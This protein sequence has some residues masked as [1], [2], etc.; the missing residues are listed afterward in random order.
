[1][2]VNV[3]TQELNV[4]V[5]QEDNDTK[6][7]TFEKKG[8]TVEFTLGG[9]TKSVNLSDLVPATQADR[10]L[11]KVEYD[12]E[13][14]Q[15]VFT[16]SKEGDEDN[17]F[18][19]PVE[20]IFKLE[21]EEVFNNE[22]VDINLGF[23]NTDFWSNEPEKGKCIAMG[24]IKG[25]D[26]YVFK[27]KENEIEEL[28][29]KIEE[30]NSKRWL[31]AEDIDGFNSEAVAIV[32][33]NGVYTIVNNL[34]FINILNASELK[35]TAS[36]NYVRIYVNDRNL[37]EFS[38][39]S[40]LYDEVTNTNKLG[41]NIQNN[42]DN[43]NAEDEV[44]IKLVTQ[45]ANIHKDGKNTSSEITLTFTSKVKDLNRNR[46]EELKDKFYTSD[47]YHLRQKV[48]DVLK[49]ADN[50]LPQTILVSEQDVIKDIENYQLS[51][52]PTIIKAYAKDNVIVEYNLQIKDGKPSYIKNIINSSYVL[53]NDDSTFAT[54]YEFTINNEVKTLYLGTR[55]F[56]PSHH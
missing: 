6:E 55:Y 43:L 15:L 32:E 7:F 52:L 10:F 38:T 21:I 26:W 42:I 54:K 46:K 49:T 24:K 25:T 19:I 14:K 11:S 22:D 2:T 18:T 44:E 41:L 20:D 29:Q 9:I 48:N 33:K 30:N 8:T 28:K 45:Y 50:Q 1:M 17:T 37:A 39:H 4:Y 27:F 56:A 16:T 5:S 34:P 3:T 51:S 47:I 36:P 23:S 35:Q 40:G 12:K 31:V 13:N 53:D